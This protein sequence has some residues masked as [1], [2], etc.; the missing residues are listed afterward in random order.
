MRAMRYATPVLHSPARAMAAAR[1]AYATFTAPALLAVLL[2][3]AAPSARAEV[4]AADPIDAAMRACL[5]RADMSSTVGQVQCMDTAR[6][7]WRSA[8]DVAYAQILDKSGAEDRRRWAASQHAWLEWR[9]LEAKLQQAV[10]ETTSGSSYQLSAADMQL[11]PVRDRAL[12]LRAAAARAGMPRTTP[13]AHL[14]TRDA[15]CEHAT[16]DLNRYYRVLERKMPVRSRS[17]LIRAERAWLTYRDATT[18]LIDESSLLDIL[19]S[20]V[21]TMKRL[22]ETVGNH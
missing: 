15:R 18:P 4:G 8:I 16:F 2:A 5:A 20:R 13:R 10:F 7:G 6:L 22:S 21:A 12:A 9:E 11:Q 3:C 1:A 19:G 14:C 17:T